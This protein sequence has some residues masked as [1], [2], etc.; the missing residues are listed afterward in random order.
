MQYLSVHP[1]H[2]A[3]R[4]PADQKK[5]PTYCIPAGHRAVNELRRQLAARQDAQARP[6]GSRTDA[7]WLQAANA[8]GVRFAPG[9]HHAYLTSGSVCCAACMK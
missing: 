6:G 1:S 7:D 9:G 4:M 3:S 2:R 5:G 8:V